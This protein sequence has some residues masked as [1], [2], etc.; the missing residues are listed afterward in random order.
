MFR[1]LAKEDQAFVIGA[2]LWAILIV[3]LMLA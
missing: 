2:I 3:A 1:Q